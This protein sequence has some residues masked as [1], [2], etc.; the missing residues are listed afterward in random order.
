MANPLNVVLLQEIERYNVLLVK[1]SKSLIDLDAAIQGFSVMTTDLEEI[2]KCIF[3]GRVPDVWSQVYKSKKP[4]GSWTR[5]L[6]ARILQFSEWAATT[7]P[8]VLFNLGYFT[9]PT[10]FLTAV[11]QVSSRKNGVAIDTL[12]W[13]FA[14]INQSEK[15]IKESPPDGVYVKGM[16]LEGAAF[17]TRNACLIEPKP[18]QLTFDMPVICFKPT[19]AKKKQSKLVYNCPVY[20]YPSRSSS[21]IVTVDLKTAANTKD[22][23]LRPPE[24]WIKRGTALVLSLEN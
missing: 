21:F 4:L 16:F 17:D 7:H 5:D 1:I 6:I 22:A 15:H 20:Y 13:E 14:I 8:P 2:F 12:A 9:F 24:L 23:T 11:L 18:M 10:G 19:E 3:D